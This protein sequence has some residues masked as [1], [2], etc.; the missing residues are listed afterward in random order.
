MEPVIKSLVSI[1]VPTYKEAENL[2]HLIAAVSAAMRNA[3][4]S[5]EIVV[6][7][8]DSQDGSEECVKALQDHHPVRLITRH[9]QRGLS[10]AV[11][12]GFRRARGEFLVCMD[13]DLSHP[14]DRIPALIAK[15]REPQVDFVIGSR[16]VD[17]GS[18]PKDWGRV[19]RLNSWVA[20]RLARPLTSVKDPM[21]GFFA[22]RRDTL[23]KAG[24]SLSPIGY[25]IG[26]ELLVKCR[27]TTVREVPIDF[28]DR[29]YGESK[30]GLREQ[31][32]YLRHL[33]RLLDF[34]YGR[35]S[36][37]LQFCFVGATG[38]V[39]DLVAF[40]LLLL[41]VSLTVAR[42]L[43][44]GVAM[45]SNFWCNRRLTFSYS[46]GSDWIRSFIRFVFSCS[47]GAFVNWGV[48]VKLITA[49]SGFRDHVTTAAVIGILCGAVFNFILSSEW[50]FSR[51]SRPV[52]SR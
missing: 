26:L 47:L 24:V 4:L 19:R 35:W 28:V 16:H 8:D 11:L 6:I 3:G 2:P 38:V 7:D 49:T 31:I 50:V 41:V 39:V 36:R 34:K 51:Q 13:G 15:L 52:H 20:T 22:L 18:I 27:C 5:Y 40:N 37:L 9:S 29:K 45:T 44:V 12:D 17:G 25:K 14:A 43:A 1:V 23:D 30:L 42:A 32:N 48:S 10:S 33:K 46:R 21:A